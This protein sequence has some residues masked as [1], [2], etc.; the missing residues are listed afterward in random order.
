MIGLDRI[1]SLWYKGCRRNL[2][3]MASPTIPHRNRKSVQEVSKISEPATKARWPKSDTRHW[4]TRLYKNAYTVSGE[5]RETSDWCVKIRHQGRRETFNLGSPNAEAAAGRALRIHRA[6][7]SSGWDAALAEFKPEV[8]ARPQAATVGALIECATRLSSARPASL[9]TYAKALRRIASGVMAVGKGRKYD[10]RHGTAKWRGSVDT[11]PLDALT[12]AAVLEWKNRFLKAAGT[13]EER[14]SAAVT[15]NSLLRNSKALLSKKLRPFIAEEIVLPSPLWFEGVPSE[16]EPSLRYHSRIDAGTILGAAMKELAK[17][18]PEVFKA[19]LLALVCGLRRSEADALLWEQIDLEAGTLEVRD[20]EHKALK[21]ADSAGTIGLD[22][23]VVA[24]L[25]GFKAKKRRGEF[26]LETPRRAKLE[27]AGRVSRTYRCDSTHLE[28]IGWLKAQ[29]V[30]GHRP[31]HTL[32]KEIGSVIASRE[33]IFAASRYLRHS[34]IRITSRL[35]ADTKT[36]VRSG[37]GHLLAAPGSV[38]GGDSS[39]RKTKH[40]KRTTEAAR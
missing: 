34:D 30:P 8:K 39:G 36:P 38:I 19:L 26:V 28:L 16:K 1:I 14:N 6:V 31:I 35:Y 33:G 12:P 40:P 7:V 18:K 21:S 29:G 23:E 20:T 10:A 25:R 4:R 11:I 2:D 24:L 15:V 17:A 13:P 37:L 9:D 32:R 22:P 27:H 3:N 5:H